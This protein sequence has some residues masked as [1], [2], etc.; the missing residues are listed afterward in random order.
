MQREEAKQLLELCRPEQENDRQDPALA[1]AFALLETDN[2]LRAWFDEQQATDARISESLNSIEA[3]ARLKAEI[4]AGIRLHQAQSIQKLGPAET[5][6]EA[7]ASEASSFAGT[8]RAQAWWLKPWAGIAALFAVIMAI[9][10]LPHDE[11]SAPDSPALAGLPPV[12]QFLSQEIDSLALRGFDK[13]DDQAENLRAFL[14]STQAPSP[15]TIPRCLS[16]MPTIGCITFLYEGA[17]L[18]MICFNNGKVYH[19]ITSDSVTFPAALPTQPEIFQTT[20]KAFRVWVEGDQ[21]K[22]LTV[23]GTKE[24]IPEFI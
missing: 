18:S 5:A 22:I 7:P 9:L 6:G 24:D 1:D 19:L 14:A 16:T 13:R 17:Q 4:L 15:A 8:P 11:S 12:I 3:P 20:D 23:H 21:V 10:N 2:E